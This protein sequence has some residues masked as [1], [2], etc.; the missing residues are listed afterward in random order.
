MVRGCRGQP[1]AELWALMLLSPHVPLKQLHCN[2]CTELRLQDNARLH[3]L[4]LD[5]DMPI[6]PGHT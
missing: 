5:T 2:F 1:E 6:L 3:Q 4:L